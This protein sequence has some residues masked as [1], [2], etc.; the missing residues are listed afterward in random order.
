VTRS[1]IIMPA[2]Q[3]EIIEAQG[4]YEKEATRHM[5]HRSERRDGQK[6]PSSRLRLAT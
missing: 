2:A 6:E 4:W 1:L 3:F 5:P